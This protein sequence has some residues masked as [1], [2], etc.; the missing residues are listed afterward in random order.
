MGVIESE[1]H[2]HLLVSI[3]SKYN[4][5]SLLSAAR[6]TGA[7]GLSGCVRTENAHFAY[8]VLPV[9]RVADSERLGGQQHGLQSR[10]PLYKPLPPLRV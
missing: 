6:S 7:T 5:C 8:C 9:L 2:M 3:N 4:H 10:R 1:C